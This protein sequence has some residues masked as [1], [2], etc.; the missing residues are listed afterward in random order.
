MKLRGECCITVLRYV[1]N[2]FVVLTLPLRYPQFRVCG[3][4]GGKYLV[5]VIDT[6]SVNFI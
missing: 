6:Y 2:M 1:I 4:D 3:V 5:S